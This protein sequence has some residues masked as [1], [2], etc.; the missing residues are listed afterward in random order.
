MF[1]TTKFLVAHTCSDYTAGSDLH[2]DQQM[3]ASAAGVRQL[4]TS[5]NDREGCTV[6]IPAQREVA[7]LVP[8]DWI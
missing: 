1:L 6:F 5:R 4:G 8:S 2:L 3:K 7:V